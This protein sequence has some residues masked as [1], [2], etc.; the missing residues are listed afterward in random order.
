MTDIPSTVFTGDVVDRFAGARAPGTEQ[1]YDASRLQFAPKGAIDW[2]ER[3]K[4]ILRDEKKGDSTVAGWLDSAKSRVEAVKMLARTDLAAAVKLDDQLA[5][6]TSANADSILAFQNM[7]G[8]VPGSKAEQKRNQAVYVGNASYLDEDIQ[9]SDGRTVKYG[10]LRSDEG[11]KALVAERSQTLRRAGFSD[12]V[13]E[14]LSGS[15]ESRVRLDGFS[16]DQKAAFLKRSDDQAHRCMDFLTSLDLAAS[17]QAGKSYLNVGDGTRAIRTGMA[18]ELG[19]NWDSYFS[20]F[21]NGTEAFTRSSFDTFRDA[22]GHRMM[23]AL[24]DYAARVAARTGL[25]GEQLVS[26]VFSQYADWKSSLTRKASPDAPGTRPDPDDVGL[27]EQNAALAS[28]I[29]ALASTDADFDF[30]SPGARAEA[31]RLGKTLAWLKSSGV[32]IIAESRSAGHDINKDMAMCLARG[33]TRTGN[34]GNVLDRIEAYRNDR[35]RI[36]GGKDFADLVFSASMSAKDWFESIQRQNGGR[37]SNPSADGIMAGINKVRDK[38]I[39]PSMIRNGV[40]HRDALSMIRMDQD[41][42]NRYAAG[43]ADVFNGALP[44]PGAKDAAAWLTSR[45]LSGEFDTTK[46]TE[47]NVQRAIETAADPKTPGVPDAVRESC[48]AWVAATVDRAPLFAQKA[49]QMQKKLTSEHVDPVK[50]SLLTSRAMCDADAMLSDG[51]DWNIPF[52][53]VLNSVLFPQ[54]VYDENGKPYDYVEKRVNADRLSAD[55]EVGGK[56]YA[57]RPGMFQDPRTRGVVEALI[58][59]LRNEGERHRRIHQIRL[60]TAARAEA[61]EDPESVSGM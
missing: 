21:G 28:A 29:S 59:D 19:S 57:I 17:V 36:T 40:S 25:R 52:D 41:S 46:A 49:S 3:D 43:I 14:M 9:L 7:Q 48:R 4:A 31:E 8:I 16:D 11:R 58:S 27:N 44:G 47:F 32:N 23:P 20:V 18:N 50:A 12:D 56:K 37:S 60:G 2:S 39:V 53:S 10:F 34:P 15:T 24:R 33:I 6:D 45:F 22:G 1:V 30:D 61:R 54:L 55:F 51:K 26:K 38:I 5:R 35:A 42:V 13:A